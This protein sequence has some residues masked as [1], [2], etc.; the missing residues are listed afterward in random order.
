MWGK[1]ARLLQEESK[2][3][4]VESYNLPGHVEIGKRIIEAAK[5]GRY[6]LVIPLN[7]EKFKT[8]DWYVEEHYLKYSTK[9]KNL[10]RILKEYGYS[11]RIIE[12]DKNDYY[13]GLYLYIT[14]KFPSE[15]TKVGFEII[16]AFDSKRISD[17]HINNKID[18][19]ELEKIKIKIIETPVKDFPVEVPNRLNQNEFNELVNQLEYKGYTFGVVNSKTYNQYVIQV[20]F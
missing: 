9:Y 7:D 8:A 4:E 5:D 15:N 19:I 18:Y 13:T 3:S 11:H 2:M 12:F 1:V 16:G 17:Q 10:S 14:W 6:D 20:K